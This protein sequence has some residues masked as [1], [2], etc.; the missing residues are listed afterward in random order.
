MMMNHFLLMLIVI[1]KIRTFDK[2]KLVKSKLFTDTALTWKQERE[3]VNLTSWNPIIY[4]R[5]VPFLCLVYVKILIQSE[6]AKRILNLEFN[7]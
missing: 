3:N 6:I 1:K 5:S 4:I 7:F 2:E